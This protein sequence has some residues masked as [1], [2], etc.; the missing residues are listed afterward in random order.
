MPSSA[1]DLDHALTAQLII[2]WAGESGVDDPRLRWWNTDLA[3]EFGG[4]DLFRRLLPT[5]WPWAI[6]RALLEAARRVHVAAR[7]N[8]SDPDQILL[9]RSLRDLGL[10]IPSTRD[11]DDL[12]RSPTSRLPASLLDR[13]RRQP[14]LGAD[15]HRH[16]LPATPLWE[17]CSPTHGPRS[18]ANLARSAFNDYWFGV[19]SLPRI[20]VLMTNLRARFDAFPPSVTAHNDLSDLG[21]HTRRAIAH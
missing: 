16:G 1:I 7:R 17:C 11:R 18:P 4:E 19:R 3:S 21:A 13:A 12:R 5:T 8:A 6:F 9:A 2:A 14:R 20:E 10:Q 15:P